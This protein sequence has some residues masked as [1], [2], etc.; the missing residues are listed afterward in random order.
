MSFNAFEISAAS[1]SPIE[2]Y[3]F[4][5][6]SDTYYFTSSEESVTVGIN[7]YLPIEVSRSDISIGPDERAQIINV[8]LPAFHPFVRKY[9]AMAPGSRSTMSL[10][11]LHRYDT[12]T[13]ERILMWKGVVRSVAFTEQGIKA[14][15]GIMPL[16]GALGRAF[17]RFTYQGLCNHALYDTGCK[18]A[19]ASFTYTANITA[20]SGD[21]YT[22]PGLIVKG[23]GWAVAGFMT[24]QANIDYRMII[25]QS[26]DVVR[27]LL[28]FDTDVVDVGTS[29]DV[30]AGCD[31]SLATCKTKF[32]NVINYGGFKFVPTKNPFAT[33]L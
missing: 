25:A 11:K 20:I 5:I 26:S 6:A 18:V 28:P 2:L 8:T 24:D 9:I 21:Q 31:H 17:P 10:W 19:E 7:E 3:D 27:L 33:G 15:V 12:P 14:V 16:T 23:A 30:L 22:V 32:N 4:A 1:G 29:V 13:P